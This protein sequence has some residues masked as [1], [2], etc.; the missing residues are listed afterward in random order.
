MGVGACDAWSCFW[1]DPV[2]LERID[3]EEFLRCQILELF[4][5]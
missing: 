4:G 1:K 3:P 5:I 2:D